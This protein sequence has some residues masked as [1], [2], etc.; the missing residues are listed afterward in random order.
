MLSGIGDPSTLKQHNI[1]PLVHLPGIGQNL[2]DHPMFVMDWIMKP[3]FSNRAA[4]LSN[5]DALAAARK[6]FAADGTGP[7]SVLFTSMGMGYFRDESLISHA[8]FNALPTTE[9]S[10]ISQPNV[11]TWEIVTLGPVL[12]PTADPSQ[13]YLTIM[14]FLHSVQSKGSIT[15]ASSNSHDA[16]LCDPNFLESDFDKANMIATV[17]SMLEF[18]QTPMLAA[19]MV[20]VFNA[21]SPT[22]SDEDILAWARQNVGA[23]WHPSCTAKMGVKED[24]MACV[25][26]EFR[27]FGT[28]GLRVA[29]MSVTPFMMNCHTQSV[30]YWI[31]ATCAEKVVN[32]YELDG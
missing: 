22:S 31:G 24:E 27:V 10:Y 16:P 12:N 1:T 8:S 9:K 32:E 6:Q 18:V 14:G 19:D 13:A 5:P 20:E 11:P 25:D 7:L 17:R 23:T 29:D 4:L 15:L 21:P 26:H 30:A 28:E 2:Q 3:R